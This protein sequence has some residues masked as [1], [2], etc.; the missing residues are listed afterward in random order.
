[1]KSNDVRNNILKWALL[2]IFVP[3]VYYECAMGYIILF[4]FG[5]TVSIIHWNNNHTMNWQHIFDMVFGVILACILIDQLKL[6]TILGNQY[7]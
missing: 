1:M 7:L 2:W 6:I 3:T 5:G 4:L